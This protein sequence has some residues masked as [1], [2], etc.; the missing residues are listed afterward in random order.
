MLNGKSKSFWIS[1]LLGILPS[2][3]FNLSYEYYWGAKVHT[4]SSN[5]EML[6][7]LLIGE[8]IPQGDM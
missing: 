1:Y 6:E 5:T 4:F 2:M 8:L 7:P 3:K